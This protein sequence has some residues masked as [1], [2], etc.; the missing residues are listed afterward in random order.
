[1]KSKVVWLIMICLMVLSLI[2]VSCTP[3]APPAEEKPAPPAEEKPAPP[4]ETKP[5]QPAE[6]EEA[7]MVKWK[8]VKTDGTVVEKWLEK[9]TYGGMLN[10]GWATP[11]I[12]FDEYFQLAI[13]SYTLNYTNDELLMGD[14]AKGPAGTGEASWMYYM[15]PEQSVLGCMLAESW[16]LA[17]PETLVFHIR[18]GVCFHNKP[19][20]NGR[21]LN[22]D[23]VVFSLKRLWA[24]PYAY[25]KNSYPFLNN[26]ENL[27]ESIYA[28]DKWTV[29]VKC[30]PGKTGFIYEMAA[31]VSKILP[32]EI[33]EMDDTE[34]GYSYMK[35][36]RSSIGT[37][38][39]MLID[40]VSESSCTFARNPNYWMKDPLR[41]D[42]QLPYLDGLKIFV[43]PD[44][45]TRMA[46]LRTHK[47]DWLTDVQWEDA[48][49]IVATNPE[50]ESVRF[51]GGGCGAIHMRL[52]NPELPFHDI[53]VRRALA[54]S[55]NNKEIVEE[56]YGGNAEILSYP[57]GPIAEFGDL[58]PSLDKMPEPVS[59]LYEYHP[60]KA[61]QLLTEAGYPTGFKTEVICYQADVDLL[62]IVQA[63]WSD[64]GVDSE[65]QVKE[66]GAY[67]A[68]G[69]GKQHT[70]M[71]MRGITSTQPFKFTYVRPGD[72]SNWSMVDDPTIN[73]AM[74]E[75]TN[76]YFDES[77][78]RRL[79]K[80]LIPYELEQCYMIIL[81][82]VYMYTFWTPWVMGYQG[83]R[84]V[85]K[86]N[87]YDFPMYIWLDQNLKKEMTGRR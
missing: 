64:I 62:S 15:M 78:R 67:V 65:I 8:G 45:S 51:F 25:H 12:A 39:F 86:N 47:I 17:D 13:W 16:E 35:D 61:R 36:W 41:T 18:K 80:E 3:P 19:P 59:E 50:L 56:Y 82:G 87:D 70:Q 5:A 1:M 58:W 75:I 79:L 32:T 52:D 33:A 28:P 63:C 44:L 55:I 34:W 66:Y 49:N 72:L 83:E 31:D 69:H 21:E 54:M 4:A 74:D 24:S 57:A 68:I 23:D 7:E 2:L 14:W 48:E 38:P 73:K 6:E 81:P 26:M 22:A 11:P 37:G 30:L 71:Y 43:I 53:R 42:Y 10:L 29:V 20:V 85:G 40:Y 9:P 77:K 46:A 84:L 76:S 60:E 27:N